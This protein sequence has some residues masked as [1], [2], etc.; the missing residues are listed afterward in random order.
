MQ[1]HISLTQ[2]AIKTGFW[3]GLPSLLML[4]SLLLLRHQL[5]LELG[6]TYSKALEFDIYVGWIYDLVAVILALFFSQIFWSLFRFPQFITWSFFAFI[7]WFSTW[8]NVIHFRFFKSRLEWWVV[9]L[10][11]KDLTAVSDS[12]AELGASPPMLISTVLIALA[13]LVCF[14]VRKRLTPGFGN[15][16]GRYRWFVAKRALLSLILAF[17]L[18]RYPLWAE[19][20]RT[21]ILSDHVLKAW[22]EEWIGDAR[23]LD[24]ATPETL[25]GLDPKLLNPP[26]RLLALFRDYKDASEPKD[27]KSLQVAFGNAK[28]TFTEKAD[29]PVLSEFQTTEA[30]THELR[31]RLGLPLNQPIN[32]IVLF[33]ESLRILE[34]EHPEIGPLIFPQLRSILRQQSLFF[35]QAYSSSFTAGQTVRGQFTTLCSMIPN[36]TGPAVYLAYAN[37]KVRC[38]QDL[39][40]EQGYQ[41]LW[42][43]TLARSFHNSDI[44]ESLHGTQAFYDEK[45]FKSKGIT[46]KVGNWGLADL[47]FLEET[48]HILEKEQ[49][50]GKPF[51]ANVLTI[52]SHHPFYEVPEGPLPY[53]LLQKVQ[54]SQYRGYLSRFEYVDEAL[55]NFI[56]KFVLSPLA[57]NTVIILLGDHSVGL[58]PYFE[59]SPV[60]VQEMRFRI[61]IAFITRDMPHPQR[62]NY[63]VHQ[64]DIAPT[65]AR[66]TGTSGQVTWLGRDLFSGEGTPWIYQNQEEL[67]YRTASRACYSLLGDEQIHCWKTAQNQD[68]LFP[69]PLESDQPLPPPNL[70]INPSYPPWLLENASERNSLPTPQ[71]QSDRPLSYQEWLGSMGAEPTP[72]VEEQSRFFRSVI[73]AN[74]LAIVLNQML[75]KATL[76]PQAE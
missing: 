75:Q 51:F 50:T 76:S 53:E 60:Q 41:T 32:V 6:I 10:H 57:N 61:P 28:Q 63:P 23:V 39:L 36:I 73:Q 4:T 14:L 21:N 40:K 58:N 72:E 49:A 37:L 15:L 34:M 25:E 13:L 7:T 70:F 59:L 12:S 48:L 71:L 27:I 20:A 3:I 9:R 31:E 74:K 65:I 52:S 18:A 19:I 8:S 29:A 35:T 2:P 47:P 69:Q 66:I 1:R 38:I 33:V 44:F 68:L 64:M 45:Y 54:K 26:T 42:I 16:A 24:K 46:Q 62:I 11:W 67:F 17:L 5:V 55:S 43:H 30:Q 22:I 56:R